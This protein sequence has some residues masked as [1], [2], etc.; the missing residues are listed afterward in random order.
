[1]VHHQVADGGDNLQ[2]WRVG[3]HILNKK[4]QL[5]RGVPLACYESLQLA[6]Q[7]VV[8]AKDKFFLAS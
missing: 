6:L 2:K 7:A 8:N 4:S 5:T 3:A 1:M